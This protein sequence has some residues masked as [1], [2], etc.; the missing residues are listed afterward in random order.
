M[1]VVKHC[2]EL[3][4]HLRRAAGSSLIPSCRALAGVHHTIVPD[5]AYSVF[6]R[7]RV[8]QAKFARAG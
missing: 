4:P 6:A 7:E 8:G 3:A 5:H 1:R 2:Q